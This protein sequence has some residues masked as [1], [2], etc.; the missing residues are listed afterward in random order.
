MKVLYYANEMES[1]V[2]DVKDYIS[3]CSTEEQTAYN[4]ELAK[5]E[6]D[7][8]AL[9]ESGVFHDACGK[10]L[11]VFENWGQLCAEVETEY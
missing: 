4:A 7:F 6:T 5:V 8:V 10:T 11:N 1:I 9:V 3:Q 2:E